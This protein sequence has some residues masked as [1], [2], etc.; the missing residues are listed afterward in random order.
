MTSNGMPTNK[1]LFSDII[2]FLIA[3]SILLLGF[4]RK[5]EKVG[6]TQENIFF[7]DYLSKTYSEESVIE[8]EIHESAPEITDKCFQQDP[9]CQKIETQE[10]QTIIPYK[11]Q[12]HTAT[13]FINEHQIV[14]KKIIDTIKKITIK[15]DDSQKRGYATRDTI[16]LNI[17]PVSDIKEF[18]NL[19]A[20]ELG[21]I[22]DL[23]T[24]QGK[25]KTKSKLFTE[26]TKAV[27]WTDDPSILFYKISRESEKVRK[28]TATKKDF[29]SWYGMTN[30]FEDFAECFNLF[31]NNQSVFKFIATK[32]KTLAQKYN[33]IAT[34]LQGQ[35]L[36]K[37][38]QAIRLVKN[39][40][41]RRPW[42]TTKL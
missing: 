4:L 41:T 24:I 5:G 17:G 35:Y 16:V 6:E 31:I 27:F 36:E 42:D 10:E 37:N 40:L 7:Q 12:V 26:F 28:K 13:Y 21:H 18:Q 38:M 30:P 14:N 9:L 25:S 8:E 33:F 29:C 20:H 39:D 22:F 32:N 3:I 19:S 34:L 15:N 2:K 23:W 1:V 11:N